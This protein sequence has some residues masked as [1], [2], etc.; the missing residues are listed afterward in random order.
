DAVTWLAFAR[1]L[2]VQGNFHH[3][4]AAYQQ[5]LIRDPYHREARVGRA[6]TLARADD[7]EELYR[8]LHELVFSDPQLTLE[9]L[10]RATFARYLPAPRFRALADEARTQAID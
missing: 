3:A 1:R 6:E 7:A 5:A 8:F 2:E 9:L 4:A 10:G